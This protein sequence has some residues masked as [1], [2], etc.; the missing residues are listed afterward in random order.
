[1]SEL[2]A[3]PDNARVWIYQAQRFLNEEEIAHILQAGND[4]VGNWSSHGALLK[5]A[6]GVYNARLLVVAV[7]ELSATASGCGIDKSVRFIE[8]L[9]AEMKIDFFQRTVVLYHDGNAWTEAALH[10]F[11]A[12]RKANIIDDRTLVLDTTVRTLGELRNALE[13]PFALSWH[14]EMWGR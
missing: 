14:S 12:M 6:V 8:Q 1:M 4:F 7:D 11:W 3:L 9:S 5:A 2:N 13:K 10:H